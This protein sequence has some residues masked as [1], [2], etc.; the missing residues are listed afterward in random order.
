M[1]H[2][3]NAFSNFYSPRSCY[4]FGGP[5][6]CQVR[7]GFWVGGNLSS[8][9]SIVT[10][11]G[12]CTLPPRDPRSLYSPGRFGVSPGFCRLAM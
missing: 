2:S 9:G 1:M 8:P 12:F 6:R 10:S 4:F 3:L 5:I 7:P 11:L